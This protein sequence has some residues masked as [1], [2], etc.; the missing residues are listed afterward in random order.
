MNYLSLSKEQLQAKRDALRSVYDGYCERGLSLNMARGK[1]SPSQ[2]DLSNAFLQ[3]PASYRSKDGV[4]ARNYSV[5][6]DLPETAQLFASLLGIPTE[7]IIIGG[8]SSLN[9]MYD[10]LCRMLLFGTLGE[11][12]WIE[13]KNRK[14]LCPAP[15]YDRHFSVTQELGFELI[16][17]PMTQDGPDMDLVEALVAKDPAIKGIWCVPLYSNPQGVCYSDETVRR[18]AAMPTAAPDFRIMWDN[19][20]GVHHLYEPVPL[21]DIFSACEQ[22]GTLDRVFYFFSTSKISFPGGGVSMMAMSP[23]NRAEALRHISIQTIGPDKVNQLRLLSVLPTAQAV[24]EHME[25]QAQVLRPRFELVLSAL[26]RALGGTGLASWTAPKGGYFVSLDTLPGCAKSTVELAKQAGVTLTGAGATF[27]YKKDPKDTNIRIA[28]TLP[29]LDE[30]DAAM[31][32]FV[33]CAKLA[34][35]EKL[36]QG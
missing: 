13:E 28:P 16:L 9:L 11:R 32:V 22:A 21:M 10:T 8:N 3:A 17:V 7:Y 24:R 33:C 34:Y 12:P 26:E 25:R 6:D 4:D 18:L 19:A 36:L 35:T 15:G 23:Q 31:D 20:Y 29:P 30:L 2:L 1:P 5:P 27:P 14:F